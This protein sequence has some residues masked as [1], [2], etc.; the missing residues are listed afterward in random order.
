LFEN[1][2]ISVHL[3]RVVVSFD[4]LLRILSVFVSR[5]R[6]DIFGT[7]GAV[8]STLIQLRLEKLEA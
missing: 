4:A 2:N 3:D 8:K 5:S 7:K 1:V 6:I